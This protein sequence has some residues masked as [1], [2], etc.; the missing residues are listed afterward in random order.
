MPRGWP[1]TE[2]SKKRLDKS[3]FGCVYIV[4]ETEF[5]ILLSR[6][7]ADYQTGGILGGG[8]MQKVV[9]SARTNL[10]RKRGWVIKC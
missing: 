5:P 2:W 1:G 6:R 9:R 3:A 8:R 10:L 4:G 7:N